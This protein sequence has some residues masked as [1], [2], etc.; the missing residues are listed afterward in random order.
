MPLTPPVLDVAAGLVDAREFERRAAEECHGFGLAFAEGARRLVAVGLQSLGGVAEEDVRVSWNRVLCGRGLT[1][2]TAITRSRAKPR[3]FPSTWSKGISWTVS[4]SSA[5]TASQSGVFG[6]RERLAVG[7]TQDEPA[8]LADK[9]RRDVVG[10]VSVGHGL[11]VLPLHGD[12]HTQR[13]RLLALLDLPAER[14]P[15][16]IGRH[17]PGLQAAVGTLRPGQELV[18]EAVGVELLVCLGQCPG[19]VDGVLE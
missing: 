7:L 13:D 11:G 2:L 1:G 3:Q 18:A 15:P 6:I 4:A 14:L 5:R 19:L 12:G 17:G 9:P 16:R 10:F 8:R